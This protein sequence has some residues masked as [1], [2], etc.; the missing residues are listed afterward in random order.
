MTHEYLTHSAS[1]AAPDGQF[2]FSHGGGLSAIWAV[3]Q[4]HLRLTPPAPRIAALRRAGHG[5]MDLLTVTV[6]SGNGADMRSRQDVQAL[7]A[8]SG[9][10]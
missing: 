7:S 3:S 8:S 2:D 9:D 4:T 6:P 1:G 10:R 5:Q